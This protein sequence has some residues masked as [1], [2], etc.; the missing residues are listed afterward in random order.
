MPLQ[1]I[2]PRERR[3]AVANDRLAIVPGGRLHVPHSVA[4]P[5]KRLVTPPDPT[6]P[7]LHVDL[8]YALGLPGISSADR[9]RVRAASHMRYASG[10]AG[11][12]GVSL[13]AA[14]PFRVGLV[15]ALDHRIGVPG[16]GASDGSNLRLLDHSIMRSA[17]R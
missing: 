3:A 8:L 12:S 15:R 6:L 10:W 17:L 9:S 14:L 13:G 16:S 2:V 1:C 11:G 4:L 5:M 7:Q